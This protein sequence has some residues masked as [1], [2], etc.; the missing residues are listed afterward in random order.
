MRA[1]GR[2][3]P[4]RRAREDR[5]GVPR[6]ET[7]V[8]AAMLAAAPLALGV[9]EARAQE[10]PVTV[11]RGTFEL[12][13]GGT[14]VGREV[15]EIRREGGTVRAV[16]R[17]TL[18][19]AAGPI[20]PAEVWLQADE[21]WRPQML[22]FRPSAGELQ[23]AV[24]VR[25]GERLRLQITT[26]AGE[27]WKEY[28]APSDLSLVDPRIAHHYA[29]LLRQHGARLGAGGSV[30][31]P[32]VVPWA[33]DRVS[34]RLERGPEERIRLA[35]RER[36]AVRYRVVTGDLAAVVWAEDGGVLR[37]E[38]PDSGVVAVRV[39]EGR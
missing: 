5:P 38:W 37:V 3:A 24:A 17:I 27:R 2:T 14:V 21:G 30:T 8:L 28:M 25:E 19:S 34:V 16:G 26:G 6:R 20:L 33:R 39:E 22:R 12:R 18:D 36:D 9:T 11:D 31:V 10:G 13:S 29:F 35:G 4:T 1:R 15:F 32:A 23:Q 7:S